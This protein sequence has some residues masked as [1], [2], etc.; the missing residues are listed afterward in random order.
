[1]HN[2]FVMQTL[3]VRIFCDLESVRAA[4]N[5]SAFYQRQRRRWPPT[6]DGSAQTQTATSI[7]FCA[8]NSPLRSPTHRVLSPR[9]HRKSTR[10]D[11]KT[12]LAK[13]RS[14]RYRKMAQKL[15]LIN[16]IRRAAAQVSPSV[17][18]CVAMCALKNHSFSRHGH[19]CARISSH[20][21]L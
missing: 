14:M 6:L 13:R 12:R 9:R 19:A 5:V 15:Q 3:C 10:R 2:T 18:F 8:L 21:R 11:T 4:P 17:H 1:M 20:F 7:C 16:S